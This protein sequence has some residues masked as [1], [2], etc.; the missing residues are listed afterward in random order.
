[1]RLLLFIPDLLLPVLLF[2]EI[3]IPLW[4]RTKL[5]PVFRGTF[6]LVAY[7]FTNPVKTVLHPSKERLRRAEIRLQA[8]K[9]DAVAA[10]LEHQAEAIEDEANQLREGRTGE[11]R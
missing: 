6:R 1:M 2:T 8:A 11:Q 5:F 9:A 4:R 3:L 10:R 7:L